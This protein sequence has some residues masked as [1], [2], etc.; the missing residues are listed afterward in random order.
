[1]RAAIL[2]AGELKPTPLARRLALES[3]LVVAADGGIAHA[4]ELGVEPDLWVGDFD[5]SPPELLS[6]WRRVRREVHPADKDATDA[7]LAAR[8]ALRLGA[9]ELL[10]L[11]ALG[12]EPDHTLA[13]LTLAVSLA[14][15]GVPVVLG[16]GTNWALP[17]LPPGIELELAKD[18]PFS[19]VP[20]AELAGLGVRGARW[21][22]RSAR[23][24]FGSTRTLRNRARGGPLRVALSSGRGLLF[25]ASP[26]WQGGWYILRV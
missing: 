17:L 9:G 12:S 8:A 6:R 24:P 23:V 5:S 25:T 13:N 4:A 26:G 20:L 15:E 1:M 7:E 10:F 3:Q 21:E 19:V 18:A 14:E 16:D 2:L 11:G 22:L